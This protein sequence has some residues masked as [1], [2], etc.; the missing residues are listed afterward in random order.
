V[1]AAQIRRRADWTALVGL[2]CL[3]L[4]VALVAATALT[5]QPVRHLPVDASGPTY[6]GET[7]FE[8]QR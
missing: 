3:V 8:V 7:T 4:A 1:S 2:A 6:P 5:P